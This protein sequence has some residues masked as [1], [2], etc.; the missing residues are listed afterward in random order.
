[1]ATYATDLTDLYTDNEGTWTLISSGG[2]GQ[3][4]TTDPETDDYIQG[5]NCI[6]RNPWSSSIRGIVNT[7]GAT[8]V[9][10]GDAVYIWTKADVAQALAAKASG[11]IQCLIGNSTTA[12]ECYYVSGSDDPFGG[13]KCYAIDP[14]LTGDTQIGSPDGTTSVFGVRWNVP[15]SGPSK[16]FPFKID[17][18]RHGRFLS[19]TGNTPDGTFQGAADF[20]GNLT[21]QWGQFQEVNGTFL[22]QGGFQIGTTAT[23]CTF[24]DSNRTIFIANT[25]YVQSGFNRLEFR[26]A[27]TSATLENITMAALGTTSRGD[28]E[29]F[30]NATVALTGCTFTDMGTFDFDSN[31]DATDCTFRR[32]DTITVNGGLLTG[33][34]ISNNRA[35][36][37]VVV[38]DLAELDDCSFVSDGTGHA[39]N[40]GTIAATDTMNWNN[41]DSGYAATDGSTGNETILV[42]VAS[43]QTLTINVGSGYSTPTVYNTGVG[44]VSVVS[45]QVTTTVTVRDIDDN[46][47]IENARVYVVAD[48]GGPLSEGT[49][50]ID[51][52]LTN[53]S[54]QA[55]DTRS[56][57]SNQ[58]V[59]GTVR[60]AS[61][62]DTLYKP[63]SFVGTINNASGLSVTVQM[64][65]DE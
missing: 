22:M 15:S 11:G 26:N 28:V 45:G 65:K 60:K 48:T 4:A 53:A 63:A 52:D 38:S 56:F 62:G 40:L 49:V 17:A 21:R 34:L 57:A 59:V 64:I 19:V 50:I 33:C 29:V 9:A 27:S 37:A 41:N 32:T 44:S 39:V 42:S 24:S 16:G 55:S 35:T 36:S 1:M 12:L 43:G 46:S 23:A 31:T 6:S 30:N 18:I 58:P 10:T 20:Q 61:P 47:V 14:D 51:K 13:W 3:N 25:E 7:I 5:N 8:T 2:G 54:G